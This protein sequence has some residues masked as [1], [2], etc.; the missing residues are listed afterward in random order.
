MNAHQGKLMR[1]QRKF[2][3]AYGTALS[4]A[5]FVVARTSLIDLI[6]EQRTAMEL[7]GG[8]CRV[9]IRSRILDTWQDRWNRNR[10]QVI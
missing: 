2:A 3:R 8:A 6:A 7:G 4:E 5:L 9:T 10:G 1:V